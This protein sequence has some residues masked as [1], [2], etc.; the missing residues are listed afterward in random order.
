MLCVRE[1]ALHQRKQF[2]QT[3]RHRGEIV[4]AQ[5]VNAGN[6]RGRNPSQ[7]HAVDII[8]HSPVGDKYD[9]PVDSE[10]AYELLEKRAAEKAEKTAGP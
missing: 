7:R 2:L 8:V 6:R 10:S 3:A 4:A 1:S 5:L 9:T